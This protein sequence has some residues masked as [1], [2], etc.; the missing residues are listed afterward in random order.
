MILARVLL[1]WFPVDPHNRFVIM[2]Y[3]LT[4]PI[5]GL[6]RSILPRLGMIDLSPIVAFIV[7]DFTQTGIFNLLADL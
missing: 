5:L 3:Q 1:S 2:L 6:F 4:E 7:L